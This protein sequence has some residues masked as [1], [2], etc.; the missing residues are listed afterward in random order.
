MILHDLVYISALGGQPLYFDACVG[1]SLCA[2]V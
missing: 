2:A 1:V